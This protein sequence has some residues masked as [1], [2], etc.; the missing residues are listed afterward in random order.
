M[1]PL[2]AKLLGA[3]NIHQRQTRDDLSVSAATKL[4]LQK[5][6]RESRLTVLHP[7]SDGRER[8]TEWQLRRARMDAKLR[9]RA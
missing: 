5:H 9:R 2:A 8:L 3:A 1:E 4:L 7:T 6:A